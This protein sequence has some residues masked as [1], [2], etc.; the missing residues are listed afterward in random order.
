MGRKSTSKKLE[1]CHSL[2]DRLRY[3]RVKEGLTVDELSRLAGIHKTY[4]TKLES[5]GTLNPSADVAKHLSNAVRVDYRWLLWGPDFPTDEVKFDASPPATPP[6][7]LSSELREIFNVI[8]SCIT[9]KQAVQIVVKLLEM[10]G[11]SVGARKIASDAMYD[12]AAAQD[13]N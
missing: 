6:P 3:S 13:I 4:V 10:D 1:D 11:P 7:L 2:A 12:R 9:Q 8:T 5:G